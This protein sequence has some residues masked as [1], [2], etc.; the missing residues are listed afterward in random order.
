VAGER[1]G[2]FGAIAFH[3]RKYMD[4]VTGPPSP[5]FPRC[6]A[7]SHPYRHTTAPADSACRSTATTRS[8]LA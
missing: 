6:N 8:S 7:I 3:I 4:A 2:A 1:L 5:W